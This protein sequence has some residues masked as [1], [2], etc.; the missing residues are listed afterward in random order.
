M[1]GLKNWKVDQSSNFIFSIQYRDPEKQPIDLT[2]FNVRMDIKS[3][4]GAKKILASCTIGDGITVIPE[5]G[6]INVNVS[7]EKTKIIAYP[8]SAYDLVI[9]SPSGIITR[10]LEGYLE[11]SRA[12]TDLVE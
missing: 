6:R 4:P 12:V 7:A 9:E 10:L 1:A 2:S 3:T 11:I 5:E 8:K